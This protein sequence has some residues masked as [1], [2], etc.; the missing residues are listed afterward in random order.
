MEGIENIGSGEV[1]YM[2]DNPL[3]R[4]FW[5]NGKLI[6]GNAIFMAGQ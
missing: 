6:V 3:F 1:I 4:A 2:V 5:Y